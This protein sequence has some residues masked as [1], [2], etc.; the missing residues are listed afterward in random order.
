VSDSFTN[1]PKSIGEIRAEK[2]GDGSVW[3]PRDAL[4]A[5]LR[6]IDSGE[7]SPKS[8]VV[9]WA[10]E[11]MCDF[12]NVSPSLIHGLGLI[13]RCAY[14]MNGCADAAMLKSP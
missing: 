7:I 14:R 6:K 1:W 13:T 9:C 3:A 4:I 5:M 11:R 8:L 2:E 12:E 10:D